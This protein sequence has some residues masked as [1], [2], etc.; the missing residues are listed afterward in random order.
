MTLV[1]VP[2]LAPGV[3]VE[4]QPPAALLHGVTPVHG[5][6]SLG[7]AK[8]DWVPSGC[9]IVLPRRPSVTHA[10]YRKPDLSEGVISLPG[11]L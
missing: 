1:R 7:L 11:A 10:A 5:A 9:E 2:P 8:L 3:L 6:F 4:V